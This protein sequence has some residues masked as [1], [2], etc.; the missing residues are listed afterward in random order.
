MDQVNVHVHQNVGQRG[1]G[2]AT[3]LAVTFLIFLVTKYWWVIAI[4]AVIALVV[5]AVAHR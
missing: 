4:A 2:C 3:V 1:G 5:W